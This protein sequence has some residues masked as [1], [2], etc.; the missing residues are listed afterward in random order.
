MVPVLLFA[1]AHIP[2]SATAAPPESKPQGAEHQETQNKPSAPARAVVTTH[3]ALIGGKEISYQACAGTLPVQNEAGDT[4]ADIFYVSYSVPQAASAKPR[5]LLF[6]FNGGPGAA[7][8]WL[9]LGA[10]G[11]RRVQMMPDGSMPAPPF[12]LVDNASSWLDVAD[13]VFVDPVGTGYSRA[14]KPELAKKFSAVQADID[15]LGRFI[16]LYLTRNGRWDVPIYLVG[17]SYGTFRCAGLAEHLVEHGVA[18]NGVILVSSVLNMQTITFDYGN[19]LPY[20]LFLPSYTATAWYHHKLDPELQ[21][22]LGRT[23]AQAE[24]WAATEYLRALNQGDRLTAAER[25]AIAA[26]MAR[27]TGLSIELVEN[28]N[29]RVDNRDFARELLRS[30]GRVVGLMDSRFN[31]ENPEP[32]KHLGFDA[33]VANIRPPFTSAVNAYLREELGYQSDLEYFVLGGGI[34]RWDWEAKNSYA[35]TSENLRDAMVKNPYLK[36]MVASGLFDLATP[37]FATDYTVAHMGLG[38]ELRRNVSVKRYR[39]GHMM[40]LETESLAQLKADAAEFIRQSLKQ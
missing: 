38:T 36:V 29:L 2:A 16:R 40:Y 1:L 13:L 6:V 31:A 21:A 14:A 3:K 37:H 22:D 34:G 27:F 10:L 32:G 7:S 9:H 39:S 18:L 35:D 5:P 33:T 23:L 26:K 12:H 17:E 24:Q 20:Q 11:P 8:V 15:S 30:E 4:E 25:K 28:R 19:D